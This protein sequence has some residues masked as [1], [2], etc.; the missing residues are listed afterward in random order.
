[1]FDMFV[2]ADGTRGRAQGGL[3][4]GL[5]LARTLV[6]M[7]GGSVAASSDGV[8][9]GSVFSVRLPL[10]FRAASAS[11][12]TTAAAPDAALPLRILIVDDNHDAADMLGLLLKMLGADVAVAHDGPR[13]LEAIE[14]HD[15]TVVFLDLGMPGMDGYEVARR[16]RQ[17][18]RC[19]QAT[20]IAL[21]G[22]G[23]EKDRRQSIDAG[24]DHHLMKPADI[25]TV[26][27]LLRAA[28]APA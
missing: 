7:H 5:T 19:G 4:I 1:V 6:E 18:P 28:A 3:G 2:Q 9:K 21:S 25:E 12:P 26:R 22:W 24:F 10:S 17:H 16:I 11:E 13:A 20:L 27:Q 15:P 14:T 23:Q 8:G